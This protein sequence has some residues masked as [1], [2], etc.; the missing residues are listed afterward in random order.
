MR[1]KEAL[2]D[3]GARRGDV[4]ATFGSGPVGTG[5]Y[6]IGHEGSWSGPQ[7]V[8]VWLL[9]AFLPLVPLSRWR[10]SAAVGSEGHGEGEALELTL[11]SRSGVGVPRG[12]RRMARAAGIAA[13]TA[14]PLAFGVWN[15]GS[16]WATPLLTA[17]LG[18]FLDPGILGKL[19]MA[20][21][22]G[23]V[24]GGAALP[25]LALMHLDEQTPRVPFRSALGTSH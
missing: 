8:E 12:L 23:V 15:V 10:V 24:V 25:I 21:E 4:R 6:L 5:T 20:I 16:P 14:L 9:L 22:L 18:A 13:L 1:E 3:H 7:D 11:H 2:D 17:L 19:G